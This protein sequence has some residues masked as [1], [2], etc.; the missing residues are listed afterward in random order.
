MLGVFLISTL[1]LVWGRL[2]TQQFV[3]WDT[4]VQMNSAAYF[5]NG[6]GLLNDYFAIPDPDISRLPQPTVLTWF[7]PTFSIVVA[8]LR[9]WGFSSGT[10]LRILYTVAALI[11]WAG[12]GCIFLRMVSKHPNH[13][14]LLLPVYVLLAFLLP[15]AFTPWP[16]GTDIFL[17]AGTA[18]VILLSY[19]ALTL[20][21]RPLAMLCGIGVIIGV[22]CSVRWASAFLGIY[23]FLSIAQ[24][25]FL[26]RKLLWKEL[27]AL[28]VGFAMPMT[29]LM[30][31][32]FQSNANGSESVVQASH[33]FAE[34]LDALKRTL[35]GLPKTGV[36]LS[37]PQFETLREYLQPYPSLLC[38]LGLAVPALFVVI[39]CYLLKQ[40]RR[41][42]GVDSPALWHALAL[43][44]VSL[45]LI[46][47]LSVSTACM[48]QK[49]YG[50]VSDGRYY[51]PAYLA[52]VFLL[53]YL[54]NAP[55]VGRLLKIGAIGLLAWFT[56]YHSFV[57]NIAAGEQPYYST[58]HKSQFEFLAPRYWYGRFHE[59]FAYNQ[60][61]ISCLYGQDAAPEVAAI[62]KAYPEAVIFCEFQ[63]YY[64]FENA[65]P[66]M[67]SIPELA[68]WQNA[69][70]SKPLTVFWVLVDS[71]TDVR[72]TR[73]RK[74]VPNIPL[75]Q[76]YKKLGW[77]TIYKTDLPA[78][79]RFSVGQ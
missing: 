56:F 8:K 66:A 14:V 2:N 1:L 24:E 58:L 30:L 52:G 9:S 44:L 10:A 48:I 53:C 68:Y 39:Y 55:S 18:W 21:E 43:C 27:I 65:N 78:D 47:F 29:P 59:F 25:S 76:V 37:F 36:L 26:R 6:Q 73:S 60:P 64:I 50:F 70:T 7:P 20:Q 11:G 33:T 19:R 3:M 69:Y 38:L 75:N 34:V 45:S 51:L 57:R 71:A 16:T 67:R 23:V 49:S 40:A 28:C 12:W 15:L 42:V 41:R 62:A 5:L 46:T 63:P 22:L 17:W 13:N 31:F 35:M 61:A 74:K 54:S 77:S 32:M 4:G 72:T 79:Y